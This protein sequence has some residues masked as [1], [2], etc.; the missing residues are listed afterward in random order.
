MFKIA[1]FIAWM[2]GQ[3][4]AQTSVCFLNGL[5][6]KVDSLTQPFTTETINKDLV[7]SIT[8][9]V[10]NKNVNSASP[11]KSCCTKDNLARLESCQ[12]K[13][14]QLAA[15]E[16]TT[17]MSDFKTVITLDKQKSIS[18]LANSQTSVRRRR[19]QTTS[20]D[21]YDPKIF[22]NK[23]LNENEY[24]DRLF[25]NMMAASK[26]CWNYYINK[27]MAGM[28]CSICSS[29]PNNNF[30]SLSA[31][32]YSVS[33]LTQSCDLLISNCLEAI[34]IHTSLT[35]LMRNVIILLMQSQFTT[36][37]ENNMLSNFL[38]MYPVQDQKN[39]VTNCKK[40]ANC[41]D[42][43]KQIFRFGSFENQY[44]F[45]NKKI[46]RSYTKIVFGNHTKG[47]TI[48]DKPF[49]LSNPAYRNA[50]LGFFDL[51][52]DSQFTTGMLE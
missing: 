12:H 41:D 18:S 37:E 50:K 14:G 30:Y 19:L 38:K 48:P 21:A 49:E 1:V 35:E 44:I 4:I 31:T 16:M 6:T 28:T 39:L 8:Y 10:C 24:S 51:P 25:N 33:L 34:E 7:S 42:L 17:I 13:F 9:D 22:I 43:C 26:K 3:A 32:S 27:V 5:F 11:G 20:S 45:G 52:S 47:S 36:T 40:N 46:Y 2:I 15:S 23:F 29:P